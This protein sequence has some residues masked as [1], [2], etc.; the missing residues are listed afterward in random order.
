MDKRLL[1]IHHSFSRALCRSP[2][3]KCKY[4]CFQHEKKKDVEED[5]G[6]LIESY[7]YL[8]QQEDEHICTDIECLFDL[9]LK[10][11]KLS[12]NYRILKFLI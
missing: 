8:T 6:L 5:I 9:H 7:M 10:C 3:L 12:A 1:N 4:L 11:N 2:F